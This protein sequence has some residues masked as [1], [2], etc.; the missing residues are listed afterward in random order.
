[1]INLENVFFI[2]VGENRGGVNNINFSILKGEF[3][4]L[5]GESG[6]G[7]IIIIRFINGFILYFYE[8]KFS[9]EVFING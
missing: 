9:G 6:C 4:V 7:K 3:I 8:G 1:M 2:Y 5:C